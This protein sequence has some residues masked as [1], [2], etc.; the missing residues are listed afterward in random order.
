M[1]NKSHLIET[2]TTMAEAALSKH[3][4]LVWKWAE[5]EKRTNKTLTITRQNEDG[6]DVGVVCKTYGLY[7]TA[8]EWHGAPWD[9]GLG[10]TAESQA[11]DCLNFVRTLLCP[12]SRLKVLTRNGKPYRWRIEI[13]DGK[14]WKLDHEVGLLFFR[15]FG[16][17]SEVVFQNHHLPS[18]LTSPAQQSR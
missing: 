11:Q 3:G 13:N 8:G 9:I 4:H 1:A 17:R 18:R 15:F 2:F 10:T 5:N 7:P 16:R 12:D 6:F 14:E